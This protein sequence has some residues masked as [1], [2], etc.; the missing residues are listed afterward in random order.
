LIIEFLPWFSYSGPVA[1]HWPARRE[2]ASPPVHGAT[3]HSPCTM[4]TSCIPTSNNRLQL[5]SGHKCQPIECLAYAKQTNSLY[6]NPHTPPW[7]IDAKQ[8]MITGHNVELQSCCTSGPINQ[9]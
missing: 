2:G 9:P 3:V 5:D 4:C 8:T 6:Q 7:P 1:E